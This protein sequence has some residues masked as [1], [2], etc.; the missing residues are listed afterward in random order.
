MKSPVCMYSLDWVQV[1]CHRVRVPVLELAVEYL[2]PNPDASGN[3]RRYV[4]K[5]SVEFIHG[6]S[7]Q[8]AVWY[9]KYLVATLAIMPRNKTQHPASA[10]VKLANPV[11]Y[12]ADWHFI[13]SDILATFSLRAVSLTRVDLCCDFNYFLGGLNP[14]TFIRKYVC[15]NGDSYIKHGSNQF[16][17]YG[18]KGMAKTSFTSIR[19]G[20]RQSGVSVYLYNKTKELDVH[21]Y[22]P[23]ITNAW[24]AHS[25]N[26]LAVWRVELSIS[27][28]GRGLIGMFNDL[29]HTLFVDALNNQKAIENCF[30][31]Y[32]SQYF[33][34]YRI[35]KGCAKRKK[36]LPVVPLLP[37]NT[38]VQLKPTTLYSSTKSCSSE[39]RTIKAL[40]AFRRE[41]E[42]E[43]DFR[44]LNTLVDLDEV[45]CAFRRRSYYA[46]MCN[47][48]CRDM[49]Q[50]IENGVKN[51]LSKQDL[52]NRLLSSRCIRQDNEYLQEVAHRIAHRIASLAPDGIMT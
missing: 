18:H 15:K 13:L 24:V 51:W 2:S 5:E 43:H 11:L 19:W 46:N 41:L 37:T 7:Q 8:Y 6:Y 25:I 33:K 16:A 20:S 3:H 28:S 50:D 22:K 27:S 52:R 35:T 36:D 31:V 38:D 9:G 44:N 29:V 47:V 49:A 23:W 4:L 1:Y 10:A 17:V 39:M 30:K 21:K 40:E 34:F 42:N 45:I 32:A 48:M 14:E 26:P 12:V